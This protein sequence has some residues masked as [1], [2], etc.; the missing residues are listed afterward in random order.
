MNLEI[1][2]NNTHDVVDTEY[3]QFLIEL[4]S[5]LKK[6]KIQPSRIDEKIIRKTQEYEQEVFYSELY[7][8]IS[9]YD[10]IHDAEISKTLDSGSVWMK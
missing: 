6:A 1:T 7:N 3:M 4:S 2:M 10:R 8:G 5:I 9:E